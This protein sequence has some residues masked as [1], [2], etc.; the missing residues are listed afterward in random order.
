MVLQREAALPLHH[1]FQGG[2]ERRRRSCERAAGG[3]GEPD[4]LVL[5]RCRQ[6]QAPVPCRQRVPGGIARA[7]EAHVHA[8][9][10][11]GVL[12][13]RTRLVVPREGHGHRRRRQAGDLRD[14]PRRLAA[15]EVELDLALPGPDLHR[16]CGAGRGR[17]IVFRI[18][19][20]GDD[21][22]RLVRHAVDGAALDRPG[23][24]VAIGEIAAARRA[25]HRPSEKT[26]PRIELLVGLELRILVEGARSD[27]GAAA[28]EQ[29]G[30]AHL[31]AG[32]LQHV[33]QRAGEQAV[34][35]RFL[36]QLT[37]F[38]RRQQDV[39][40]GRHEQRLSCVPEARVVPVQ[41]A[42]ERALG[43]DFVRQARLQPATGRD[44]A[45]A[46][47]RVA[48]VEQHRDVR[49]GRGHLRNQ[50]RE[51]L[52]REVVPARAAAVGADEPFVLAVGKGLAK[53][54]IRRP[55][56]PVSAEL[57][58]R[59]VTGSRPAGGASGSGR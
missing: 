26:R 15:L 38:A 11:Q 41:V 39:A 48:A 30:V 24:L 16:A 14:I 25:R 2:R 36:R 12:H 35:G 54:G 44:L 4:R 37:A 22:L 55:L 17:R 19:R 3:V 23:A 1:L 46:R 47:A 40:G 33:D 8:A 58:Q 57:E 32:L 49:P 13:G 27:G 5:P 31:P 21:G 34:P 42:L 6:H 53:R 43:G 59:D 29:I 45:R 52:V 7:D 28:H 50:D 51:L 10:A 20:Q 18:Q 56:R 9:L